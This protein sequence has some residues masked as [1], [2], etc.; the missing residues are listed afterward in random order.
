MAIIATLGLGI[1]INTALF[2]I[3]NEALIRQ[4]PVD[5]PERMVML[6]DP[7]AAQIMEGVPQ[8]RRALL[9][10]SEFRDL[11]QRATS[12]EG[13][14]ASALTLENWQ[15]LR[16][17][18]VSENYFSVLGVRLML[19]QANGAVI[20]YPYWQ[21]R[22]HGNPEILG[23]SL[24]ILHITVP[25]TGLAPAGFSG[26]TVGENPDVWL[27][28]AL[29]PHVNLHGAGGPGL[30]GLH[31][32]PRHE[33]KLMWLH[34]FGRVKTAVSAARA[35]AEADTLLP[36]IRLSPLR[37]GAFRGRDE[38]TE[39]WTILALLAA[40]VLLAGCCNV[41]NLLLAQGMRRAK[42]VS[43]RFALGATRGNIVR[44]FLRESLA[45]AAAGGGAGL[46]GAMFGTRVL[47][48]RL[49]EG[50]D[51]SIDFR[52]FAF[53]ASLTLLTGF[54]SGLA[55]ALRAGR[56][57]LTPVRDAAVT[58][59]LVSAQIALS[60]LLVTGAGL[61]LRT[62]HNLQSAPLG[63]PAER[64]LVAEFETNPA[65][66]RGPRRLRLFQEL[67]VR[68]QGLPGVQ[69]VTWSNPGLLSGFAGAFGIEVEG[70]VQRHA[71]D[72]GAV[73]DYIGPDYFRSLQIPILLGR[74]ITP[75]DTAN[76]PRVCII[77][78]TFAR[79]FFAG[80]NPLGKHVSASVDLP[81]EDG[82]GDRPKVSMKVVGVAKDTRDRSLRGAIVQHLYVPANQTGAFGGMTFEIL[83]KGDPAAVAGEVSRT[84]RGAKTETFIDILDR[85]NG[86]ARLIAEVC[87]LFGLLAVLLAAVGT[88]GMLA[89]STARRTREFGVRM[90]VGATGNTL[91]GMILRETT[92]VAAAGVLAGL[93]VTFAGARLVAA[94][95]QGP[96]VPPP[97]WT[98]ESYRQT[99][100]GAR[101]YGVTAMDPLT[102][103]VA[104][105]CLIA[106]TLSAALVPAVRVA[107]LNPVNALRH[108]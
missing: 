90:A 33:G 81:E 43:I 49:T 27:P 103:A 55:P 13:L 50:L 98:L 23:T 44:Q 46:L 51:P 7:A 78:E 31:D 107:R 95:L 54:L 4:L 92:G 18:F 76:A 3:L 32:N 25:I 70:Y 75:A 62:L 68:L 37:T 2:S 26:E 28:L 93:A 35:Q 48:S 9:G 16:G 89:N 73:A 1:G 64:L 34:V 53:T 102:L 100:T 12:F 56:G 85:R 84:L 82:G 67:T 42:E 6:T 14:C 11:Q 104:A 66:V 80:R 58:R 15:G 19:G 40:L 61:F 22:F 20:S 17:R 99:E 96:A 71:D 52:G 63:Y 8:G 47:A 72:R 30:D 36:G 91:A 108:E 24:Q 69:A 86:Q 87:S 45:L 79:R 105:A 94:Q 41:A 5:H 74:D 39:Q 10:Y 101:L 57:M 38:F 77:N 60:L 59:V 65:E 97:L 88:A 21:K 83:A 29:Q 106:V